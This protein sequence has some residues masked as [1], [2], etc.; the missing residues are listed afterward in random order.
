MTWGLVNIKGMP[1]ARSL[2]KEAQTILLR[3]AVEDRLSANVL[4]GLHLMRF[5][6]SSRPLVSIYSSC[7]ALVIQGSK[8]LEFGTTHLEYGAGQYLLTSIDMPATSR[9]GSVGAA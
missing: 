3:H 9:F 8:S 1:A 7:M 5:G 6:W 2:W 4:P